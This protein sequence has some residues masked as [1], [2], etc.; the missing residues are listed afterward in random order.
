M[1]DNI[2]M[3]YAVRPITAQKQCEWHRGPWDDEPDAVLWTMHDV[4][5]H[6]L[7][8]AVLRHPSFGTLNGYVGVGEAHP[9]F[10]AST[11]WEDEDNFNPDVHGGLTYN[12]T[13][14]GIRWFGFDTAHLGD[15]V[16]LRV[17]NFGGTYRDLAYVM[18][19]VRSLAKQVSEYQPKEKSNG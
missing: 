5:G 6:T 1:A 19:E 8:C 18:R 2:P 10:R 4:H 17:I 3:P 7:H 9:A 13:R 15:L 16:P 11:D 14:D 12:N